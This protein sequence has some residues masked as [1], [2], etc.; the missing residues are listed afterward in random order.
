MAVM[1]YTLSRGYWVRSTVLITGQVTTAREGEMVFQIKT[2]HMQD[3]EAY[4]KTMNKWHLLQNK[5]TFDFYIFDLYIYFFF[6]LFARFICNM[7]NLTCLYL[8][9]ITVYDNG[10]QSNF[11]WDFMYQALQPNEKVW[12]IFTLSW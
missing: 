1:E 6:M 3:E 7:N 9:C 8:S 2:K 4:I 5:S 12:N 10:V 11:S